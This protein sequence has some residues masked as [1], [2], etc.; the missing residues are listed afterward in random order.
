MVKNMVKAYTFGQMSKDM[1]VNL[2]MIKEM[3]KAYTL[4][5]MAIDMKANL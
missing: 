3:V 2:K 4:G 1:R 5:H